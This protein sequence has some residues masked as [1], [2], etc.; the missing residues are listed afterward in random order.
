MGLAMGLAALGDMD[1]NSGACTL[2]LNGVAGADD[3]TA[4]STGLSPPSA[5]SELVL[6]VPFLELVVV[7]LTLLLSCAMAMV[8]AD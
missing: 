7:H 5:S 3:D 6:L 4:A 8:A 1:T 2:N